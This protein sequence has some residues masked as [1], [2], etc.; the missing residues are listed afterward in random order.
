MTVALLVVRTTREERLL[1]A[2]FGEAYRSYIERTG[3][4]LP[5]SWNT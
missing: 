2:R 4:F 5:K 3:R 1:A